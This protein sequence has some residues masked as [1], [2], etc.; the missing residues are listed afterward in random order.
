MINQGENM[1]FLTFNFFTRLMYPSIKN[2][3]TIDLFKV[4]LLW[5]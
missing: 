3:K 4:N 5:T 1:M 2:N